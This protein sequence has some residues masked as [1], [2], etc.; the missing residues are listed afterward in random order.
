MQMQMNVSYVMGLCVVIGNF[1]TLISFYLS[2]IFDQIYARVVY[3]ETLWG[4]LL[5]KRFQRLNKRDKIA[6]KNRHK[7]YTFKSFSRLL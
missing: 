1:V 3:D 7:K 2:K 4:F 6:T 5:K